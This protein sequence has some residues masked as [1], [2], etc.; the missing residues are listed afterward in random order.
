MTG[1]ATLHA[2]SPPVLVE[3]EQKLRQAVRVAM[4]YFGDESA[5]RISVSAG[6]EHCGSVC[7]A[8]V[9]PLHL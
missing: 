7:A 3:R 1:V 2:D 4:T 5:G 6:T 8:A 9:R